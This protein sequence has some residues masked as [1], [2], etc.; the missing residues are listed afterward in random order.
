MARA[1][2]ACTIPIITGIGH[3]TD[4]TIADFAADVRASTPSAAAEL[5][6]RSRHEFER[7]F[8]DVQHKIGQQMRMRLLEARHTLRELGMHRGLRHLEDV[9]RRSRQR[10]DEMVNALAEG[11]RARLDRLGR[12]FA[13]AETR[14]ASTDLRAR[15]HA[16]AGRLEQRS[17]ALGLRMERALVANRRRVERLRLQL[18]ERSPLRVLE[19]GYAICYD[20]A[21]NV[22]SD[23]RASCS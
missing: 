5:V 11:L 13:V 6:V 14:L 7:H 1:I 8:A 15:I 18:E 16:M 17:A 23:T 4:F 21:G 12:R 20:A 19:R 3:E 22:V 2:G 10:A 9:L